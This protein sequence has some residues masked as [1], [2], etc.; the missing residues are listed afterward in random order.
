MY[1]CGPTVYSEPHI[2]N[3]RAALVGDLYYRLLK[4]MYDDVV[5]IRNLTDVDDKIIEKSLKSGI[6]IKKLTSD[7]TSVY[8]S[9]ML[10]LN[11]LRPTFEPRVT[12]NI[13]T[14]I[15]TIEKIIN[16]K[17]AYV[18]EDH[19][20]FDTNSFENYGHLSK[21]ISDDLIDGARIT[22]E[23]Y[24]KNPKDF[25]LWKPSIDT[26][27]GWNSPWGFGRP[28]WHIECTSMIKN[29]IGNDET[30]DIHG[31][32]NDL[33]FPHHENEIAQGSCCSSS[34]Y[35]NYW[36]HNGIVLVDK[37]KMSKSLGNV[38]LVSNMIAEHDP[39]V[40]RLALMSTHYRQPLNWTDNTIKNA[41]NI[42][43][44]INRA[45]HDSESTSVER[46][47]N[48]IGL[49][50]DDINTPNAI[51]YLVKQAKEL[52]N[53]R[54]N[55]PKLR[56]NCQLLGLNSNNSYKKISNDDRIK[57]ENLILKREKARKDKDYNEADSIRDQLESMRIILE[58][59]PNGVSWKIKS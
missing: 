20:V 3:A 24:K 28:G 48:F 27:Y 19:V 29:I 14:I 35:C 25:V 36:F 17:S 37:K 31:G 2:G 18:S 16:N 15:Q 38:I 34:K 45:L 43:D 22:P 40:I 10:S 47:N 52:K 30:L 23:S 57:I 46:D 41:K 13:D 1:V 59:G 50:C 39:I 42:L 11:M 33:I 58:D 53:N 26:D 51:Q 55:L 56:Y 32:G 54:S 8:Q 12:E 9:N 21:K 49:L 4:E 7:I 5:Y 44:K 6:P